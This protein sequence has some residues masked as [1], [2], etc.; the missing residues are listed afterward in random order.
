MKQMF[1]DSLLHAAARILI[2]TVPVL[3]LL[4]AAVVCHPPC[5]GAEVR[6]ITASGEYT[7]GEAE[8]P[9]VAKERA[10]VQAMRAAS[11]QAGLYLE[12]VTEVKNLQLTQD[13]IKVLT[14][15]VL[16]VL[17]KKYVYRA[18]ET[19]GMHFTCTVTARVDTAGVEQMKNRAR[20]RQAADDLKKISDDY[21][22]TLRE[23]EELKKQLA[24]A[25][26]EGERKA[27]ET[28]VARNEQTFTAVQWFEKGNEFANRRA[29]DS[30]IEAYTKA[31]TLDPRYARAYNNRGTVYADKGQYKTAV[32]DYDRAIALDANSAFAYNNRGIAYADTGRFE[33]ALGDFDMAVRLDPRDAQTYYN[34][35]S[36]YFNMGRID[37]AL[38]DFDKAV[39]MEPRRSEFFVNRGLAHAARGDTVRA[40][41]DYERAIGLDAGNAFAYNNRGNIYAGQNLTDKAL[42][43]YDRALS[44]D[45]RY[46][47]AY[48][49]RG[50]L[51]LNSKRPE[52]AVADY[53]R[54]IAIEPRYASAHFNKAMACED[55]G[56]RHDA[57]IAYK[58]FLQCAPAN[59]DQEIA[60][61]RQQ[62]NL[63][64]R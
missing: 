28:A 19:G 60:Y 48:Y 30:A 57:L 31:V 26:S 35:G 52:Q 23:N 17:D 41:A 45:P 56:R 24:A 39:G 15:A 6:T 7:M 22:K 12:S 10:A 44:I 1:L 2:R 8:T 32:T 29:F 38:A 5:A 16:E 63:L 49:N 51:Y 54:A 47:R 11:E 13:E 20:D 43:D 46:A 14:A 3:L 21:D 62:I 58:A 4:C 64:Q 25:R 55:M 37:L 33:Q 40:L 36:A 59:Y 9:L 53:D 42:A 50:N 34:R 61:A 27:V 18:T